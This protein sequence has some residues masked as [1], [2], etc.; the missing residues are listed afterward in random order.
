M[1]KYSL[2]VISK[3]QCFS[4]VIFF[5]FIKMAEKKSFRDFLVTDVWEKKIQKNS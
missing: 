2:D 1:G 5:S 3:S 4:W